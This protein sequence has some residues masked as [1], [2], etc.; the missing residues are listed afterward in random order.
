MKL[1]R[2]LK[3]HYDSG[4]TPSSLKFTDDLGLLLPKGIVPYLKSNPRDKNVDPHLLEFFVYKK[5]YH[6]F[7]RGRMFCN[8]SVSFGD[9][10][11]DLVA[12]E[13]VD[14]VEEI[15]KKLGYSK[16][17]IFC[18][19]HLDYMV[20]LLDITWDTTL[21][22][23]ESGKNQGIQI[24]QN[25]DKIEWRL[26]YDAS[27][28]QQDVFFK[29]LPKVEISNLLQCIGDIVG[30]WEDFKHSK[31]RYTKRKD[32]API[33]LNAGILAEAFGLGSKKLSEM[34]DLNYAILRS[35]SKD[36]IKCTPLSRP[37]FH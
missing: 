22:N 32:P 21:H 5:M 33:F 13:L 19:E 27:Q 30:F 1:I 12:D 34:S 16:V 18:D 11:H 26:L 7:D 8:N 35:I 31:D 10:D 37:K 15:A 25:K 3:E 36:C 29:N 2:M 20:K 14:K 28:E 23:I 9:L 17:P 6:H 4:K 24:K